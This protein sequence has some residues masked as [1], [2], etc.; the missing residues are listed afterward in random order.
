MNRAERRRLAKKK[1]DHKDLKMIELDAGTR[2]ID[3]TLD[4]YSAA[5]ALTLRDKLGF[6]KKRAQRF[7]HDTWEVFVA[8][9]KGYLSLQDVVETVKAELDIEL[10]D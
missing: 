5:V 9:D 6:G 4:K 7:M 2:A 8:I 10:R 1:I 3:F